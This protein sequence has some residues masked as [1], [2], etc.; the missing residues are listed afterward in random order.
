MSSLCPQGMNNVQL[1]LFSHKRLLRWAWE[2]RLLEIANER[3]A[4]QNAANLGVK[5]PLRSLRVIEMSRNTTALQ[6]R[7]DITR[8]TTHSFSFNNVGRILFKTGLTTKVVFLRKVQLHKRCV[9]AI[10]VECKSYTY[11]H[12]VICA[13]KNLKMSSSFCVKLSVGFFS[14]HRGKNII[15]LVALCCMMCASSCEKKKKTPQRSKSFAMYFPS[16]H[17]LS[18]GSGLKK[19]RS[20]PTTTRIHFQ[21]RIPV[22]VLGVWA[23]TTAQVV[24]HPCCDVSTVYWWYHPLPSTTKLH[25]GIFVLIFRPEEN[26]LGATEDLNGGTLLVVFSNT[27]GFKHL[28]ERW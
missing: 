15:F 26:S 27:H 23:Q 2:E 21:S 6:W 17:L 12:Y 7:F 24:N 10:P 8:K 4:T 16:K 22:V 18:S 14:V 9:V 5:R 28:G 11:L 1:E 25:Q 19:N 20:M 3:L 13:S